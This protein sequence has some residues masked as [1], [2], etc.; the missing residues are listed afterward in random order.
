VVR[1]TGAVVV[2]A[3]PALVGLV[4]YGLLAEVHIWA[5]K[6]KAVGPHT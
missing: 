5:D 1:P 4:A 3:E 2:V 6:L